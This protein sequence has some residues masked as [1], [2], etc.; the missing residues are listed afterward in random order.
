MLYIGSVE[1]ESPKGPS[2]LLYLW[3]YINEQYHLIPHNTFINIAQ[4]TD[5]NICMLTIYAVAA[6]TS[7]TFIMYEDSDV[8]LSVGRALVEK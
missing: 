6:Q 8:A 5:W 3:G 2:L 4:S 1:F 7:R